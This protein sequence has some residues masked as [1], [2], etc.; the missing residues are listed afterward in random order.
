MK[1]PFEGRGFT[2]LFGAI[3]LI[4]AALWLEFGF[5][6]MLW[7]LLIVGGMTGGGLA[8]GVMLDR[9]MSFREFIHNLFKK[10]DDF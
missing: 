1:S 4:T 9:R 8:L 2:I 10:S 7:M 3:G 5:W 6:R